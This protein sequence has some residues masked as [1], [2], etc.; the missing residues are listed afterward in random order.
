MRSSSSP[1][2][3]AQAQS[4]E[5]SSG[6]IIARHTDD[7]RIEFGW[8]TPNGAQVFPRARYFPADSQID[9]W[10]TSSPVI[11]GGTAIGRIEFAFTPTDGE[12]I[13]PPS[14]YFPHNATIGRWLRSTEITLARPPTRLPAHSAP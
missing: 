10:L 5:Q 2:P 3:V 4:D 13:L 12:R 1:V 9:R 6:Y 11:V 8:R 7:G 14:H